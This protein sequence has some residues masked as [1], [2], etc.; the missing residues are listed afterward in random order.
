MLI[1]FAVFACGEDG[2]AALSPVLDWARRA[3]PGSVEDSATLL[4]RYA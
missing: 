3:V 4:A 2:L 1:R